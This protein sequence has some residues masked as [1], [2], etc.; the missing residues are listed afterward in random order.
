MGLHGMYNGALKFTNVKIPVENRLL[1][2]GRGLAIAL[3]TINVGRLTVPAACAGGAKQM[4]S[5]ARRWG[6]S[7]VQ[8]GQPVG[9]HEEGRHKLSFI[10]A[11]TFA[12]E[13]IS[14]LTSAWQD[15]GKVDIRIEGAMAKLFCTEA[16][17]KIV[18]ETM[19]LRGG[20]G[21][22]T[23]RSLKARGEPAWGVERALRDTRIN[24]IFEGS[25]E[26]M[27]LFLAREAIDPHLKRIGAILSNKLSFGQKI[28]TA[29]GTLGF[30]SKWYPM[31]FFKGMKAESYSDLGPLAKHFKYVEKHAHK[32]ARKLFYYM[33]RYR[34][35][36]EAHQ[37][38]L[39]RLMEIGSE[40]F[41]ISATISHAASLYKKDPTN[42]TP[43]ELADYFAKM[44][45]RRIEE[46]FDALSN[47]DDKPSDKLA[48]KVI[49][50]EMKWLEKGIIS[51]GPE[52]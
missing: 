23:A 42:K 18:N 24:M 34:Q 39:G 51:V 3:A 19:Q 41:A 44:A 26:I 29:F 28:K 47:N 50:G 35:K 20:R 21:Y 22:E 48:K 1:E 7:R 11:T 43:L 17:W 10:A 4:L 45:R 49:D 38:I 32:L 30:Y 46:K 15:E 12:I 2:E 33:G 5:I 9:L 31:Q 14:L 6:K 16:L 8:W 36:L 52:E 37:L 25:S 40:L 13:A 27:R